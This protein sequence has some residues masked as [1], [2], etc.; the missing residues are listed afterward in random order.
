MIL[1]STLYVVNSL[2][3]C[4]YFLY[5]PLFLFPKV[6]GKFLQLNCWVSWAYKH[7]L[8]A[9]QESAEIC[10][11]PELHLFVL[12]STF[13]RVELGN[14]LLM[15]WVNCCLN[16][17]LPISCK[18]ICNINVWLQK[19]VYFYQVEMKS[20]RLIAR[21]NYKSVA[22]VG[23]MLKYCSSHNECI[24]RWIRLSLLP[25]IVIIYL[26]IK[27]VCIHES[28]VIIYKS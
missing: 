11:R 22:I 26:F 8:A 15:N 20:A 24:F 10:C 25:N 12:C 21:E 16:L 4:L 14:D 27:C 23:S 5:F 2:C 1:F 13:V 18:V 28:L 7:S 9:V 19:S 17:K 3:L 6:F